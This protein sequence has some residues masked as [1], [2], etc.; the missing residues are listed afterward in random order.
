M[1]LLAIIACILGLVGCKKSVSTTELQSFNQGVGAGEIVGLDVR[2]IEE[3][4]QNG[5]SKAKNIP[6]AE[7]DSRINEV[8]KGKKILVFCEAGGRATRAK[9]VLE[10]NG[11]KDVVNIGDWR[12]WNEILQAQSEKE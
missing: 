5:S 8:P 12:A 6:I 2:T 7:L 10:K 11:Y 9:Q 1:K 4:S 3:F